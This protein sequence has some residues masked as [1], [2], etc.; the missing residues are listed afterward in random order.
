ML[1]HP[2]VE[3]AV[4]A[5][6][7]AELFTLAPMTAPGTAVLHGIVDQPPGTIVR[8]DRSGLT[9]RTYW[10]LP[11][12]QHDHDLDTTISRVRGHLERI[13]AAQL[14]ADVPVCA[15]LSG[16]VDSSAVAAIA[17][18]LQ[19]DDARTLE[20]FAIDH[21]VDRGDTVAH[22]SSPFH[23]GSDTPFAELAAH[24]IK[25]QHT[26]FQVGTDE[27]LDAHPAALEAMDLPSLHTIN[28]SL[29][30]LFGRVRQ[31]APV[32]LSGEGADELF[33]GYRWYHD[34]A[35]HGQPTFPWH[36]AYP[37]MTPLLRPAVRDQIGADRYLAQQYDAALAA[38]P[39]MRGDTPHERRIREV[40]ALTDAFYLRFLLRR[41]DRMAGA[42]GVEA[43]VPFLDHELVEYATNIP[44]RMHNVAGMEK[45]VLRYA[46]EDLLPADVAWRPKS[47]YPAALLGRYQAALFAGLREL[48][49]TPTAPLWQFAEP[50]TVAAMLDRYAGDLTDWTPT[51]RAGF[52][53][54]VNT[55]LTR[56]H[57]RI[58]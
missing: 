14:H 21:R 46:V 11:V 1:A 43:R 48:L 32:V 24:H 31:S 22:T 42:V 9:T 50:A 40:R 58:L 36:R 19:R 29:L 13:V 20:T 26:T 52:L 25:S 55:W 16:G 35:D 39:R 10:T 28:V 54:E 23:Q 5:D 49:A 37:S 2:E 44:W 53:L 38:V 8:I 56:Q 17:A 27:L 51:G 41:K 3:P 45:G 4:D 12:R 57:V 7:L 6:G 30:M 47:G 33:A 34:P 18:Q 15:L